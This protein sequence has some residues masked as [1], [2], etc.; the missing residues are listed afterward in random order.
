[1]LCRK[2]VVGDTSQMLHDRDMA[3]LSVESV[4]TTVVCESISHV[5]SWSGSS[6]NVSLM[7]TNVDVGE[8]VILV[9]TVVLLQHCGQMTNG[10]TDVMVNDVL[11]QVVTIMPCA[12]MGQSLHEDMFDCHVSL[13]EE[14]MLEYAMTSGIL[15]CTLK[16]ESVVEQLNVC[17]MT[18]V[19]ECDDISLECDEL[20]PDVVE[21]F[22]NE[23]QMNECSR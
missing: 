19:H 2:S 18:V 5:C 3:M 20:L 11:T 6:S 23:C 21:D 9:R 8:R 15:E 12:Q 13:S 7:Y 17:Q 14:C 1:M 16:M 22:V 10:L 4:M